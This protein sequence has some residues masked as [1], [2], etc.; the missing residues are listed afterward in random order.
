MKISKQ[1]LQEAL[2]KVKPG[3][4]S[5]ELI[6]QTT[7]FAFMGDRVVTY[8]DEISISHPV[9]NLDV[10]G[11]VK[12]Q[13]LYEFL[14][15]LKKDEIDIEWEEKQLVIKSGKAKAGLIFEQEVKLPIEEVGE[16]SKWKDLSEDFVDVAKFCH[17]CCS[18]DMSRPIL[19]CVHVNGAIMEASDSYQI[20]V[21][22]I[23]KKVPVKK[24]LIPSTSLR[25]LV[26]YEV[27]Q[28]AEGDNWV[29]FKTK[30][31]T[32]FSSRI[33][34]GDFPDISGHMDVTGIEFEFPQKTLQA[35]EKANVF[36]K[37]DMNAGDLPIVIMEINDGSLSIKAK[38]E[39]GWF[40]ESLRVKH[41]G[42]PARFCVG[43]EFMIKVLSKLQACT[44]DADKIKFKG[45]K[46][47][48]VV[49]MMSGDE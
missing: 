22:E 28:I 42:E 8:N 12:A 30:D 15:K 9:E 3:L 27:T 14:N 25:E 29:H 23:S 39:Y 19:T 38:N 17:P 47:Q 7:S 20:I 31:G 21:H 18:K 48:H 6:E 1:Q 2:E 43:I 46:W 40:E 13:A 16:I 34:T 41:K 33:L 44:I 11:A 36:S 10:T 24:F 45:D 5:K 49:A 26:K 32:I 35:L 4:A 37:S